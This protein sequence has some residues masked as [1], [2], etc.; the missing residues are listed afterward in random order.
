MR[1]GRRLAYNATNRA[2]ADQMS[3]TDDGTGLANDIADLFAAVGLEEVEST[4]RDQR[5]A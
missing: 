5:D 2:L 3:R 4:S 1:T